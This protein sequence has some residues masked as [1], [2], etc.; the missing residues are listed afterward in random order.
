M[1]SALLNNLWDKL[2]VVRILQSYVSGWISKAGET[3]V[4]EQRRLSAGIDR[5]SSDASCRTCVAQGELI[6]G[7]LARPV[8][9]LTRTI[10]LRD[11][12]GTLLIANDSKEFDAIHFF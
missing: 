5:L 7:S 11:I 4:R 3:Q 9:I 1:L 12:A 8:R 6:G 10:H 2:G